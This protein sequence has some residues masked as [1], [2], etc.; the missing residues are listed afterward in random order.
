MQN[1]GA[2]KVFAII[3]AL[4][5]IFQL[6][7]TFFSNKV[8]S[9]AVKY[10]SND[11]A[12][13][14]ANRLSQGDLVKQIY[15]L[16]SISKARKQYYLDSMSGEVIYNILLKQ[17]TYQDCKER[18]INLGLD[19]K[20]GMNVMLEVNVV[21]IVK[22]L[23]GKS[24]D[25]TFKEAMNMAVAKQRESQRNFLDLF[26]ESFEEVDP[27]ARLAAIF[28]YEFKNKGINTNS[29]NEEVLH[30][31]RTE[32]EGA[33]DRSYQIIRTRIDRFGVAQPNIQRLGT[34]GRIL[35]EL[36]GI[37]DPE[38]VRKLLQGTA[39]LEFWET[40][41]FTELAPY[42][43][44]ANERLRDKI[45]AELQPEG[46]VAEIIPEETT[47][48][49]S[50]QDDLEETA[51]GDVLEQDD[52]IGDQG[53]QAEE[54]SLEDLISK[55]SL[56]TQA[57]Q[58]ELTKDQWE[59]ENPLFS[60]LSPAYYQKDG[61]LYASEGA[62]VGYAS[63]KDTA[64]VN[65]MLRLVKNILPRNLKL[66]WTAKH[67]RWQEDNILTLYALKITTRDGEAPLSGD[68]I[69][70][71]SQ[72]YDQN[73][74]VEVSMTMNAE[75]AR[76]WKR[77]TGE[78]VGHQ[79]AI[80]LDDYVRSAPNVTGEIPT[81]QSSISGGGMTVEE[82]QDMANILKAGKLPARARIVQ[83]EVVGPSLGHEAINAGLSSFILAFVLVLLYMV[84]YYNRA[85]LVADIALMSNIFF[86]F[87]ILASLG[88]VLTLPGI[89]GIVLTLGMAVDANVIIY[90]RIK[91]EIRLGKG[92]RLAISDG[93]KN[94]Y[95]A[96][97]DGNVTTLLTGIVLYIFG[98]G[99]VQ[100]FATTLIIGIISSLFSA[101]FI[102]RLIFTWALDKNYTV[103]FGNKLTINAFTGISLDFIGKR[104]IFYVLSAIIVIIGIGSLFT[105]GLNQ[106]I[107]FTGGRTYVVRFDNDVRT[108][109]IRK[110][111]SYV[112]ESSTEVKTF[113][114]SSQVKVTTKYLIEDDSP[115]VDSIIENKLFQGVKDF[116]LE[117]I[118]FTTFTTDSE[119]KL[120]GILSS[121]KV[122]PTIADD[123]KRRSLWAILIAL[124]VIFMYI[125][126]RFKR[127][128][129]GVG[130]VVT[131]MHDALIVIA[132]YSLFH[133]ILPFNLEVDQAFIAAILTVIGYSI[134]DSVIIFDRIREYIFLHPK[135]TLK[136]NMNGAINSTLGRTFMTSGSTLLVLIIIFI[137]GGEVIRGFAFA[138]IT[139][140]IVGTYSSVFISTPVAYELSSAKSKQ[141]A[142]VTTRKRK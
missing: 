55:D 141:P 87:G 127:W 57:D 4:A 5:S 118:N 40:Y 9:N 101:I 124:V 122:G 39:N 15:Y 76:V 112:F 85:G 105:R 16:D 135:R 51:I 30:V 104:K 132:M 41:S 53:D 94:A 58:D 6:S 84:F 56:I 88:A 33:I 89:A 65:R 1:K 49:E 98:S 121:A 2:I 19:L 129:F 80:V 97:T 18:E 7:F 14:L 91:E 95:S 115:S 86:L 42:F 103:T 137:L 64:S 108:D 99:P 29:T 43:S 11:Q 90:E 62:A 69:V 117:D 46:D 109:E 63:I 116:Y 3:L 44:E 60:Y 75:G 31:I 128:E 93:Y 52:V 114:P 54:A 22:A 20:G 133:D 92:V 96:I 27:N 47:S 12:I 110:S 131:L 36:P 120:I 79:I 24:Q 72:D 32:T 102:S 134:N 113:G 78:N 8:E 100:G 106:G 26:A 25:P 21:D 61:Q 136:E 71:A 37:K 50:L 13:N 123:I 107:D 38:R 130:G 77:L 23:S 83:E 111:L 138:L 142:K 73:G 28:A 140:V 45:K 70:N 125:A 35:V 59:K 10:A 17:Y 119:D 48:D 66:V 74:Q 126:S 81:G 82:A 34:G 68:V 139:G 67:E